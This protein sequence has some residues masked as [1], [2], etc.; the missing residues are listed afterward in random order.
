MSEITENIIGA[1]VENKD[2]IVEAILD[3]TMAY[4]K[5]DMAKAVF[6]TAAIT[7][8]LI[9]VTKYVFIPVGKKFVGFIGNTVN[10]VKSKKTS[11]AENEDNVSGI[12]GNTQE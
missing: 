6:A 1:A 2:E 7:G 11:T 9:A 8:G 4:S 5:E 12:N 10:K 3:E